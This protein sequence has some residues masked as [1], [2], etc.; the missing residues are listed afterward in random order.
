MRKFLSI[1]IL[2]IVIVLCFSGCG[3]PEIAAVLRSNT[4]AL[5]L[6]I[7]N[8]QA[9]TNEIP[10]EIENVQTEYPFD[11]PANYRHVQGYVFAVLNDQSEI[12][13]FKLAVQ[14][15][16]EWEWKDCDA[17]GNLIENQTQ[18]EEKNETTTEKSNSSSHT[19]KRLNNTSSSSSD[20]STKKN[21]T[22]ADSG[23]SDGKET[24]NNHSSSSNSNSVVS[25]PPTQQK[26]TWK[27]ISQSSCPISVSN[28]FD[29]YI[30]KKDAATAS[31]TSNGST[32]ALI[33]APVGQGV[34]VNSVSENGTIS[35]SYTSSG[36]NYVIVSINRSVGI[37]F[38]KK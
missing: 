22:S 17:Q 14:N 34:K 15:N 20:N 8:P 1:V 16:A 13:G 9:I 29:Q 5:T 11:V 38:S 6:S 35:Y 2:S 3:K 32:Y 30:L 19:D 12:T 4:P 25:P 27:T 24:E 7:Y 36:S 31:A 33:K 28:T 10:E 18:P 37:N 23:I 26:F 21:N